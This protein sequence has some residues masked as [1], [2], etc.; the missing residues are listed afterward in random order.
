MDEKFLESTFGSWALEKANR[1]ASYGLLEGFVTS[2]PKDVAGRFDTD[3][4]VAVLQAYLR[5]LDE[6]RIAFLTLHSGFIPDHYGHDSSE[7]T[8]YT[9]FVEVVVAEWGSRVGF[10]MTLQ[11]EKSSKE[12]VTF[13]SDEG[14]AVCDVKSYRL[15]RSQKAPNVKDAIKQGDYQ[16]WLRAYSSENH[17]G[18]LVV[19]P[20]AHDWQGKSDVYSYVSNKVS[21]ILLLFYEHLAFF[22]VKKAVAPE[23]S[24]FFDILSAYSA[25]FEKGHS[26]S[27]SEYWGKIHSEMARIT[28]QPDVESFVSKA[29]EI[30][31]EVAKWSAEKLVAR[32][33]TT[34]DEIEQEIER[35]PPADLKKRLIASEVELRTGQLSEQLKNILRFRLPGQ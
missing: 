31:L 32:I 5:T 19:F 30:V 34:K 27:R 12:D 20:S 22:L 3:A 14:V 33:D 2:A 1:V 23:G 11:K 13:R 6:S 25:T 21:P 9:K 4:S 16:K 15:G 17:V 35:L 29:K 26:K 7:E 28:G 24:S 10:T 18:G 8:L